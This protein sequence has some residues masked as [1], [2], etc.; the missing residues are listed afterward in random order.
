MAL[1]EINNIKTEK[2]PIMI[3]L[4]VFLCLFVL[5]VFLENKDNKGMAELTDADININKLVINEIMT[6]NKGSHVD[7]EGNSYS[8]IELYNGSKKDINLYDYSLSDKD[9]GAVKWKFPN[10][11]IAKDSY[12][13]VYLAKETS[14]TGLYAGFDLKKSGGELITLKTP[15]GKI[16]DT[17]R[18]FS[19]EKNTV[20]ARNSKGTWVVTDE[21]TPGF[22]NNVDGRNA[23]LESIYE[24]ETE[25]S[26]TITEI[27]PSNKGNFNIDGS[28]YGF[29]E[30][31][32]IGKEDVNLKNYFL[33]NDSARPFLWAMPEVVL[34]PNEVYVVYT[35]KLDNKTNT[36][37]KLNNKN[38]I[39]L[40]SF[41]SEVVDTVE[42]ENL[43]N[44]YAYIKIGGDFVEGINI[45]P[46]YPNTTEGIK[47]YIEK[48]NKNPE[49]LIISEV[50][51]SNN[52]FAPQNGG[53]FYSYLVLYNNSKKTIK[54]D[55]YTLTTDESSKNMHKLEKKELKPAEFYILMASGDESLS[56]SSYK[57]ANFKISKTESLY[58]Y[59]KGKIVDSMFVSDIPVGYSYG[60]SNRDGFYYFSTPSP[61]KV[62]TSESGS[63]GISHKPS[64]DKKSGVYN[65]IK[66][67][68]VKLSGPGTIHYT[69]D[70]SEPTRNSATYSGP[71]VLE[72][73]TVIRASGFENGKTGSEVLTASYIINENHTMPVVSI[74][75]PPSSFGAMNSSV[76]TNTVRKSHA[77]LFE[78]ETSFSIDCGMRLFGGAGR[79][80]PKKSFALNFSKKYGPPYLKYKVFDNRDALDWTMLVL[81][82]G[83][84]DYNKS[85]MRDELGTS[86]V[87]DYG[88]LDV[89]SYK[90]IILYI[91]GSYWGVYYIREKT[92]EEF[93]SHHYNVDAKGTNIFR[94][95]GKITAGS[96]NEYQ[97]LL[98][99]VNK[100]D[101]SKKEHYDYVKSKLDID[102][103][104][105]FFI[106]AGY[107]YHE[108]ARNIRYFNN[109]LVDDGKFKMI[110]FDLDHG[111]YWNIDFFPWMMRST[112]LSIVHGFENVLIRNLMKND[113]FKKRFI[114]RMIYNMNEVFTDENVLGR[115]DEL[116]KLLAP[117][118]E[119]NQARWNSSVGVWN[120]EC[121]K[122]RSF[123]EA[124]RENMLKYTK[125]YFKLTDE[126]MK[127]FE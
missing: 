49:D 11:V 39:V 65:N 7:T 53:K 92:N 24:T 20:M 61:G 57:H 107:I 22:S 16:V 108:D 119:R 63:S 75:L 67:L 36:N 43:S 109:P 94:I 83:S 5:F 86:I 70:G 115:Y 73:T 8:W 110:Y 90:P 12:L 21:I 105:D 84:Q 1:K 52:S 89:Q 25:N 79:T 118:M 58:L 123:L 29:I 38:G 68:E 62:K 93:V 6:N 120:S 116:Y 91:N 122:L 32:N 88:T 3:M 51:N 31:Q 114:E 54:L 14:N 26:L 19:L 28:F 48:N 13:V 78:K 111:F 77:E 23:Y 30:V 9:N 60:R 64:I 104:I 66:N 2:K 10:V 82:S 44:G 55:D 27:L 15:N 33:S 35:S 127:R 76:W 17:I 124:R 121:E 47:S 95:D 87:D 126:E 113:E 80:E 56:N 4:L 101:L 98:D 59:K 96:N 99:Y 85:M 97:N 74:A 125:N 42:Y 41:K 112:G 50:V 37:F 34:K 102:N 103:Y 40:L 72:K 117:E 18:T 45:S 106:A 81:R 46:G 69:L 100:N 71:I